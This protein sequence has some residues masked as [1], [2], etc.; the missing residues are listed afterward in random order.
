MQFADRPAVLQRPDEFGQLGEHLIL[1]EL[2]PDE[3]VSE[4][5]D[6]LPGPGIFSNRRLD[7]G[8]RPNIAAHR[9]L[10]HAE[11][12]GH[13]LLGQPALDERPGEQR[14]DRRQ[15]PFDDDLLREP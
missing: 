12:V 1:V 9:S 7:R 5:L 13:C 2:A 14:P 15:E 3:A 4:A 10:G 8:V 6:R 11:P